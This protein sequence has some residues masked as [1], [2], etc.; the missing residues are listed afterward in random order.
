MSN[1]MKI[2]T[3][4]AEVFHA[5]GQI[6]GETDIIKLI[7]ALCNFANTPKTHISFWEDFICSKMW[8]CGHLLLDTITSR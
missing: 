8:R 1:L 6:D 4:G 7:I 3:V 2:S 5:D